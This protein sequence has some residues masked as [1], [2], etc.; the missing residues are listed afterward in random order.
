MSHSY[1]VMGRRSHLGEFIAT[2]EVSID[3]DGKIKGWSENAYDVAV[4]GTEPAALPELLGEFANALDLP[5][6]DHATGRPASK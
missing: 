3:L 5:V 1:R 4:D 6:L 2:H